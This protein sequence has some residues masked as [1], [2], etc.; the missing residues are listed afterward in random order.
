MKSMEDR[1]DEIKED[2]VKLR[3]AFNAAWMISYGMLVLGAIL[4]VAVLAYG[5]LLNRLQSRPLRAETRGAR[6]LSR[7]FPSSTKSRSGS[8]AFPEAGNLRGSSV[9]SRL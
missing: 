3:R 8:H 7:P 9:L 5:Y 2:P 6:Y 1:I 4:I